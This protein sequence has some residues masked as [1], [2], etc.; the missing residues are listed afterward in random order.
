MTENDPTPGN[1][2]EQSDTA[3]AEGDYTLGRPVHFEIQAEDPARAV[4]FYSEVF[5]WRSEDWSGF[6]G[7]PYFGITTGTSGAGIDGAIMG[8]PGGTN[9]EVGGPVM[10]AVITMGVAD[11]DAVAAKILA[12]GGTEA[13]PKY[14]LPGMAWQGY[15]HDTEN[16]VFGIHQP[17]PEAK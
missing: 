7:M 9:A 2:A 3:P 1:S 15:F 12:A 14:A 10:G 17:D 5:G 8:R 11:Y 16:N 4:A 13:L 6:A